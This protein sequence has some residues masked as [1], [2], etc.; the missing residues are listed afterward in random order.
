MRT[1]VHRLLV[2]VTI[3]LTVGAIIASAFTTAALERDATIDVETDSNGLIE[4]GPGQSDAISENADGELTIEMTDGSAVSGP[5]PAAEFVFG[6]PSSLDGSGSGYVYAFNVTV[7]DEMTGSGEMTLRYSDVGTPD[8]GNVEFAVYDESGTELTTASDDTDGTFSP[9]TDETYYVILGIDTG[10]G[11]ASTDLT[12]GD[13]LSG[14]L[15][16]SV[17]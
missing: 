16:I 1:N 7:T 10:G 11:N 8:E 3:L 12:D 17:S 6:D 5:N 4:L 2:L 13:D 15:T 14:T 9:V